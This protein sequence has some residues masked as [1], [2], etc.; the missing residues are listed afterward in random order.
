M[1]NLRATC[2]KCNFSYVIPVKTPLKRTLPQNNLYWKYITIMAEEIGYTSPL[3][4]HEDLKRELN[5]KPSKIR[6]GESYGG[7]T[8]VMS[9]LE[10]TEYVSKVKIFAQQFY[11]ISLPEYAK[12]QP[13]SMGL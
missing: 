4:L 11:G 1:N 8:T 6:Q 2:P 5:P 7:S 10:F 9:R 12:E 3:E 13:D